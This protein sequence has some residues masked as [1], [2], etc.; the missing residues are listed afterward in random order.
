MRLR[1]VRAGG[2]QGPAST[3]NVE[4]EALDPDR[5]A[6][7]Y[8]PQLQ[9]MRSYLPEREEQPKI[10]WAIAGRPAELMY[11]ALAG[12]PPQRMI[13]ARWT[14]VRESGSSTGY[15]RHVI[16]DS[17]GAPILVLDVAPLKQ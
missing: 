9:A 7:R 17:K 16:R 2:I 11:G 6:P 14:K 3:T 15:G 8:R 1:V 10:R 5:A 12:R 13:T 4:A